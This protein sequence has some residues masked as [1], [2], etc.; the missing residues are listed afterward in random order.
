LHNARAHGIDKSELVRD[1]IDEWA[2]K[3]IHGATMLAR[4]LRA[5]GETAAAEGITAASQGI[6]GPAGESP[7]E[8]DG[9]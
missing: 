4:C 9:E 5:K 1:I 2:G 7:L 3:Q 8:W 6:A